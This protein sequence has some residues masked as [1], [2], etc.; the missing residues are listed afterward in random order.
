MRVNF[1]FS[2]IHAIGPKSDNGGKAKN[3]FS[4]TVA[5]VFRFKKNLVQNDFGFF[6]LIFSK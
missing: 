3:I 4:F 6:I 2:S 1:V 5:F